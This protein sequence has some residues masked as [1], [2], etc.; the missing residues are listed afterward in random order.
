KW[1]RKMQKLR[2]ARH[3]HCHVQDSRTLAQ[4]WARHSPPSAQQQERGDNISRQGRRDAPQHWHTDTHDTAASPARWKARGSFP[5]GV[6]SCAKRHWMRQWQEATRKGVSNAKN[7][8]PTSTRKRKLTN[9]KPNSS[10]SKEDIN[11]L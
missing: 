6:L 9:A 8:C 2:F 3:W 5:L 10:R 11:L 1:D 7:W 4:G